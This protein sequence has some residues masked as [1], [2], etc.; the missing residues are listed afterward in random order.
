MV[1]P[2]LKMFS[3]LTLVLGLLLISAPVVRSQGNTTVSSRTVASGRSGDRVRSS[4]RSGRRARRSAPAAV[5]EA[6]SK[7][8]DRHHPGRAVALACCVEG[9]FPQLGN[10]YAQGLPSRIGIVW[11]FCDRTFASSRSEGAPSGHI[12]KSPMVARRKTREECA[13]FRASAEQDGG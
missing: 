9:N 2:K 3:F 10:Q 1:I 7:R 5:N 13:T 8:P 4:R 6:L 12:G 11:Y